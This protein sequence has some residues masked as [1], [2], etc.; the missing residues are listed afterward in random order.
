MQL[1]K[2]RT[3]QQGKSQK[4]MAPDRPDASDVDSG[5]AATAEPAIARVFDFC[6]S[7]TTERTAATEEQIVEEE[8]VPMV[9]ADCNN[10]DGKVAECDD[11]LTS[12]NWLHQQNL[13]K[14]LDIT[15]QQQQ[16]QQQ[17]QEQ[18]DQLQQ[19]Q[20]LIQDIL[21]KEE[22]VSSNLICDDSLDTSENTNSVS[23]IEDN[24]FYG[25][26]FDMAKCFFVLNE[27]S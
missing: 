13:L 12:L 26:I 6:D 3:N 1:L 17:Q 14:G 20:Q 19:Q 23:S 18:Q 2:N 21:I 5:G 4:N 16:Q 11:E 27:V 7:F 22:S 8:E 9:K 24:F 25:N 10:A 15:E